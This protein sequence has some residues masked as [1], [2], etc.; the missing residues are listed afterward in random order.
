VDHSGDSFAGVGL[1]YKRDLIKR[2]FDADVSEPWV[3][4]DACRRWVHQ[5]C[6]LFNAKAEADYAEQTPETHRFVCPLCELQHAHLSNGSAVGDT[7]ESEAGSWRVR[8]TAHQKPLHR[9]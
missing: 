1:W 2:K 5:T 9:E 7:S 3:R 8:G 4:C 6:A